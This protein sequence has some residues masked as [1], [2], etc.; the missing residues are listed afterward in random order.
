M[1]EGAQS[2]VEQ[3]PVD[4]RFFLQIALKNGLL[5]EPDALR[6][7]RHAL[8][9]RQRL[10]AALLELGLLDQV[11]ARRVR[12]AIAASQVV[13]LDS[14]Y[15]ELVLSAGLVPRGTIEE[16]FAEQRRQRFRV[17]VGNLLVEGG[18]LAPDQHRRVITQVI[19]RL[20][21]LGADAY[22]GSDLA[23]VRPGGGGSAPTPQ[24]GHPSIRLAETIEDESQVEQSLGSDAQRDG[25]L[26]RNLARLESGPRA[27]PGGANLGDTIETAPPGGEDDAL[28]ADALRAGLRS[29][30]DDAFQL[31]RSD[32]QVLEDDL[33]R[34]SGEP[35][36][37]RPASAVLERV[38]TPSAEPAFDP[39]AWVHR[40]RK[41]RRLLLLGL[42]LPT[43]LALALAAALGAAAWQNRARLEEAEAGLQ[44]AEREADPTARLRGLEGV[45]QLLS[46]LGGVG[47]P[48]GAARALQRRAGWLRLRGQAEAALQAERPDEAVETL[49]GR[50]DDLPPAAREEHA[51]LL[52]E[53]RRRAQVARG[54]AAEAAGDWPA[55]VVAYR[56]ALE[57]GDPGGMARGRLDAVRTALIRHMDDAWRRALDSPGEAEEAEFARAAKRIQDLFNEDPGSAER[58]REL[59][60]RRA[61]ARGSAAF[62]RGELDQ[63]EEAFAQARQLRPESRELGDWA[64][65]IA[66]R[67]K[68]EAAEAEAQAAEQA[69]RWTEAREAWLRA[70]ELAPDE[71]ERQ[72][73]RAGV[74]R[75]SAAQE[76]AEREQRVIALRRQA[77]DALRASSAADALEITQELLTLDP[78][79]GPGKALRELA[80]RAQG[81]VYIPPGPFL[82]GSAAEA[83]GARPLEQPQRRLRTPG[84]FID[85]TEV[86]NEAYAG[87]V[88]AGQAPTPA[89]WTHRDLRPDG[90]VRQTY[91]PGLAKHPVVNVTWA[92]ASEFARWRG[93]RLPN[94]AE[95]EKAARGTDGRTWPWGQEPRARAHVQVP[96]S[97][98][99]EFETAPVG[100]YADDKSPFGV[101]DMAGNVSEWTRDSLEAYP[102]AP[103]DARL[104]PEARRVIRGGAFATSFNEARCAAR[105]G[106]REG[107]Y[108]SRDVGFR[109]VVEVP[110]ELVPEFKRQ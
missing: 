38:G 86:T 7:A 106:G 107:D 4:D 91:A 74:T 89:H 64:E 65:R 67:R 26:A 25:L 109:V 62:A 16:A 43:A 55:A 20:K 96:P 44:A 71:G 15:A 81:M 94:E 12:E 36:A 19:R 10:E 56:G 41:Q 28:V 33:R 3:L 14:I 21:K 66:R 23:A 9:R 61:L 53:A 76:R 22:S 11:Q 27:V 102:G 77:V 100:A 68:L 70:V 1:A 45:D 63:A 69:G 85:R 18:H 101:M 58:L 32:E 35:A 30:G 37:P 97:A 17:R 57:L 84:Y 6:G 104:P 90:T 40:R 47:V 34:A 29:R 80:G 31:S 110:E 99:R 8:E 93:G 79:D 59:G 75:A 73:L 24:G 49:Q 95:W 83:P 46:G 78:A 51:A 82:M 5:Q 54:L 50:E 13:R 108:T 2:L 60:Y 88:V 92:Q 98:L 105:G 103:P 42:G 39:Q 72:R 48:E 87:I 52:K